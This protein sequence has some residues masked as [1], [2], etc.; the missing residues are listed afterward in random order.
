MASASYGA[1]EAHED[2]VSDNGEG[3]EYPNKATMDQPGSQEKSKI[4]FSRTIAVVAV[5]LVA[6][7]LTLMADI[8][9]PTSLKASGIQST[10]SMDTSTNSLVVSSVSNDYGVRDLSAM[11][12][13][14][15]LADALLIEPYRETT[16]ALADPYAGCT[17]AWSF[18]KT[19]DGTT[20]ASGTS[21]DGSI[22]LTLTATGEYTFNVVESCDAIDSS[23]AL[24]VTV[25]TKYVRR[26]ISTLTEADR[27]EFL[28]AFHTLWT[29]STTQ[30]IL[31]YGPK[32]KSINFF[33]TLHNDGGGNPV[34][35]EFHG[36]LGFLNNHMYLSAYLEQS[37]QLINPRVSLHY[38]EYTKYFESDAYR[39]RK[40]KKNNSLI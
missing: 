31:L 19:A 33:A 35:D 4:F 7:G 12:A 17:Y 32:Y 2:Y 3:A 11:L 20:A 30:G 6:S 40:F 29:V 10:L 37:L 24:T 5:M 14:P 15:F 23:R 8:W 22:I 28:D 27:D 18:L 26:E 21:T 1:L 36:G 34:C 38:L 9:R 13:Y 16:V 25:W 39:S